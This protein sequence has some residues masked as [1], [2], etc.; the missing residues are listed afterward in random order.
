MVALNISAGELPILYQ[1][2]GVPGVL[3]LTPDELLTLQV[4]WQQSGLPRDL[5]YAASE[6]RIAVE[7]IHMCGGVV[8][9]ERRYSPRRWADRTQR[10]IEELAIP[11]EGE[12]RKRFR[13]ACEGFLQALN[14]RYYELIEPGKATETHVLS[15][16]LEIRA[17]VTRMAISLDQE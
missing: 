6:Q 14:L 5:Y 13:Q 1:H 11:S 8:L 4:A 9:R 3:S 2:D 7:P 17:A 15:E 12:R 16:V 10:H